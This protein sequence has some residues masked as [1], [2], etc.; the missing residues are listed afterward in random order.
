[1][2]GRKHHARIWKKG[3]ARM[4][5]KSKLVMVAL[6][7]AAGG[8]LLVYIAYKGREEIPDRVVNGKRISAWVKEALAAD[9]YYRFRETLRP[10]G[11]EA[12]PYLVPAL[13]KK[14]S[15]R[16]AVWVKLWPKL[17][18]I[19]ARRFDKPILARDSRMRAVV[20]LREMGPAGK[21]AV[22]A[23]IERLS[24]TDGTIRL[25]SAIALGNIGPDAISAAPALM[26]FL[27]DSSYNVRVYTADAL[28]QITKQP[29][30]S[31]TVLEKDLKDRNASFRWATASFLGD[32]GPA[33]KPAIP[34][35][36]ETVTNSGKEVESVCIQSLAEISPETMPFLTNLLADR[37][38]AIR[39][40]A[41][42]A[43]GKL[44]SEAKAAVPLL[45]KALNDHAR[46][47]P[48]IMGR[49]ISPGEIRASAK[50]ALRQIEESTNKAE[51]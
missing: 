38:P 45:E 8:F 48:M 47:A 44:G 21:G 36:E 28:W 24:D 27:K 35:L 7:I 6:A 46:G 20:L 19:I 11:A 18:G 41:I 10:V 49:S 40:S 13:R 12:V 31:L 22:P 39:I 23:L 16:N 51:P 32:M 9:D 30:P 14:D 17:P 34:L 33:A 4:K 50:E 26:P 42:V 3:R 37:D 43:L 25:H 2:R 1:L 15:R 29:E 5:H